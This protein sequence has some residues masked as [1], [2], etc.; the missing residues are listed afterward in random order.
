MMST[1][2]HRLDM[3]GNPSTFK[4]DGDGTFELSQSR[5][6]NKFNEIL[7]IAGSSTD[8]A[9]DRAGNMTKVPKETFSGHF[10]NTFDA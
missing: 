10:A 1:S 2:S 3:T 8:V 4:E 5:V 7:T 6:H 9:H